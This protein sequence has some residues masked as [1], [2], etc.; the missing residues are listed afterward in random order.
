LSKKKYLAIALAVLL[1]AGG[2]YHLLTGG[3]A[4]DS[5]DNQA[6]VPAQVPTM[7][8][9]AGSSIVEEQAGKKLW[10]LKADTIE[11]DPEGKVAYL[12]K[13]QGVFYQQKGGTIQLAAQKAQVDMKTHDIVMQGEVK[14]TSSDG[15]VFTAPEARWEGNPKGF[16]GTGGVTLT[17]NDTVITGDNIQTDD[18]MEKAKVFGH[19]KVVTGGS[20]R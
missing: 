4:G 3:A 18:K 20:N 2:L 8:T 6:A 12:N 14:I 1:A 16:K 13:L 5:A 11:T 17:R 7:I 9:F 19:A 15:A 10:E